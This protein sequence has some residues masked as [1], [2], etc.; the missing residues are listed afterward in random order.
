MGKKGILK[1]KVVEEKK[2]K[3]KKEYEYKILT[4]TLRKRPYLQ[5]KHRYIN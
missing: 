5:Q 1:K 4:E 3:E 2:L